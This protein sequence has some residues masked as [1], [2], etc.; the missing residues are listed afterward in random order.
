MALHIN[1][2]LG[3]AGLV[4]LFPPSGEREKAMRPP[5]GRLYAMPLHGQA[6]L[7]R[8]CF[9][10]PQERRHQNGIWRIGQLHRIQAVGWS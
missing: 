8:R 7:L 2:D 1:V 6:T 10:C 9:Q 4:L 3:R 5:I